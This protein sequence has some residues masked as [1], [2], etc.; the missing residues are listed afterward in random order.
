MLGSTNAAATIGVK[1]I[2]VARKF[3]EDKLGLELSGVDSA[4]PR[5]TYR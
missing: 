4:G 5:S 1:D 3:Y 2:A